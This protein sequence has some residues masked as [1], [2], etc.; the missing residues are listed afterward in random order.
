MRGEDYSNHFMLV[1]NLAKTVQPIVDWMDWM[2]IHHSLFCPK[3]MAEKHTGIGKRRQDNFQDL[4]FCC[5]VSL[6]RDG[7][8]GVAEPRMKPGTM[9]NASML[10]GCAVL[11]NFI[12][13][14]PVKCSEGKN[15]LFHDA[16]NPERQERCASRI[17]QNNVLECMRSSVTGLDL[18]CGC[19]HDWNNSF[20]KLCQAVV[21]MSKVM[22][23][24]GKDVRA[25]INAQGRKSIEI[26]QSRSNQYWPLLQMVLSEYKR[27]PSIHRVVSDALFNGK[28]GGGIHGFRCL[29]SP[30][31]MEPMSYHQP[32]LH[33]LAHLT[34][35]FGLTLPETV[36]VMSAIEVLPNTAYY[37]C[38]AAQA[39]LSIRMF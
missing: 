9:Q 15:Q 3:K 35:R 26:C 38:A 19:H 29:K 32:F 30:C 27:M 17:Q 20:H 28:G 6:T 39:L 16:D 7:T 18:K 22:N 33:Y 4:G 12:V 21:G 14:I 2:D 34:E 24:D 36:G 25:G 11:T 23:V 5:G 13:S 37:F 31:N 8:L 1:R 10:N